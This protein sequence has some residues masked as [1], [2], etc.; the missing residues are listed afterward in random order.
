MMEMNSITL[1]RGK[2]ERQEITPKT[3][4]SLRHKLGLSQERMGRL[5][6]VSTRTVARW[7]NG[8]VEPE[9]LFKKR[10][11]GL[12]AVVRALENVGDPADVVEWLETPDPRFHNQP[13]MDLLGSSHATAELLDSI[14]QWGT[15]DMS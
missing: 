7:E 13:P 1:A 6:G 11:A 5:A 15:G 10:L 4:A 14:E 3:I 9:P 8:D 2:R 12:G